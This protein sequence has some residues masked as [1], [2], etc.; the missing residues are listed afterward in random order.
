MMMCMPCN[1]RFLS[2]RRFAEHCSVVHNVN[3]ANLARR[4]A[5]VDAEV[6]YLVISAAGRPY[7]FAQPTLPW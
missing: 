5:Q 6:L 3:R 2:W 7:L 1:Q 4:A